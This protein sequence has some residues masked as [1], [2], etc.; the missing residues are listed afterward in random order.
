LCQP[1]ARV[2]PYQPQALAAA[3]AAA[4]GCRDVVGSIK[5]FRPDKIPLTEIISRVGG[6]QKFDAA[7]L[8]TILIKAMQDVSSIFTAATHTDYVSASFQDSI[9]TVQNP[10]GALPAART[11]PT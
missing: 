6:Q 8:E 5:G 9:A 4:V 2:T 1:G 7:V 3:A 10:L 11:C